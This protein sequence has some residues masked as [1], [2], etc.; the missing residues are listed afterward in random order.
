MIPTSLLLY[1]LIVAVINSEYKSFDN[2]LHILLEIWYFNLS[3]YSFNISI[4][5]LTGLYPNKIEVNVFSFA[6]NYS[7]FIK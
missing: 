4:N 5:I 1:N 6:H 3:S 7:P 2:C